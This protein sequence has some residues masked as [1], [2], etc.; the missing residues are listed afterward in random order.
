[1]SG[2]VWNGLVAYWPM[3]ELT[4][5]TVTDPQGGFNGSATGTTI[6]DEVRIR[7]RK[8]NGSSDVIT[9]SANS[10]IGNLTSDL[11]IAAWTDCNPA[12]VNNNSIWE[13]AESPSSAGLG[14]RRA[15]STGFLQFSTKGVFDYNSTVSVQA[16][17]RHL[18]AVLD[19]AFD[20]SF[21]V[22]GVF[23]E[24]ITHTV[25]GIA[26]TT[27]DFFIGAAA[28][29]GTGAAR[30]WWVGHLDDLRIYNRALDATE[31]NQL[32]TF[33]KARLGSKNLRPRV[34]SPCIAR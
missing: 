11:T 23:R 17:T 9:V 25:G 1:M 32:F 29:G 14:F 3:N 24:Q 4:G 34:F 2:D 22:D 5:S 18:A 19:S 20:V 7:S 15:A 31:I 10:A 30:W 28:N 13:T 33:G 16:G 26:T 6:S 8:F 27:Q 12:L 21:Y